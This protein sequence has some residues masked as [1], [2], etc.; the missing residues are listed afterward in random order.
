LL[1]GTIGNRSID[2]FGESMNAAQIGQLASASAHAWLSNGGTMLKLAAWSFA[3]V[4]GLLLTLVLLCYFLVDGKRAA[5]GLWWLIPPGQR[6]FAGRVWARL[7]PIL[8]SYF[9]GV[10]AVVAF[11]VVV[12]YLGLGLILGLPHAVFLALLTGILEMIP[13]VGPAAAIAGTGMVAIQ[14]AKSITAIVGYAVY[15]TLLRLSI[16]QMFGPLMLGTAARVHPTLVIFCFL[17]G[18]FLFGIAGVILAV[19]TA[20]TVK[21]VL[22]VMY[23]D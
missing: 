6:P 15:A 10:L 3:A 19:P 22:A 14:Q 21:T 11:A 23:E 9:I 5:A 17:V 18:G 12:A 8:K 7:D 1:R 4:F 20:L 2:L 13:I 16:D